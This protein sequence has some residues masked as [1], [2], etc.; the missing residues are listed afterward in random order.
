MAYGTLSSKQKYVQ[1]ESQAVGGGDEI[2]MNNDQVFF[3]IL[4]NLKPTDT[5]CSIKY[6]DKWKKTRLNHIKFTFAGLLVIDPTYKDTGSCS[7]PP[8]KKQIVSNWKINDF[9]LAIRELSFRAN[10]HSETWRVRWLMW[11]QR[12]TTKIH[13]SRTEAAEATGRHS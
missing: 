6:K 10:Y 2:W 3:R 1:L 7:F 12:V 8:Y 5:G 9:F 13:L 4:W 11:L